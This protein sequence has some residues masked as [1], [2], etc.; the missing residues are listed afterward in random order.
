MT[1]GM[2][3]GG[4]LCR[5]LAGAQNKTLISITGLHVGPI[6]LCESWYNPDQRCLSPDT[7]S[8][9]G[10]VPS[11]DPRGPVQSNSGPVHP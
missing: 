5:L 11:G 1:V 3:E 8:R 4:P 10:R 2:E 7:G 6:S 9:S